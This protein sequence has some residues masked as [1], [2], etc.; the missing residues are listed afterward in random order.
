MSG[1]RLLADT[2][3]LIRLFA[4]EK[5]VVDNLELTMQACECVQLRFAH[6][7]PALPLKS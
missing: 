1:E 4:G 2:N 3:A 6:K 5:V 7:A